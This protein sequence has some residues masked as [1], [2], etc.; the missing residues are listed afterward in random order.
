[1]FK[2]Y[3]IKDVDFFMN[4]IGD[5][6]FVVDAKGI[7][8]K[9][10]QSAGEMLGYDKKQEIENRD[11]IELLNAIDDKGNVINKHNAALFKSIREGKK[12]NNAIRQLGKR[13]GSRIW[14]SITTTPI[15]ARGKVSG[16]IIVIRDI[17][18]ERQQEEYR[19]DFAHIASHNLRT[20]LGN[21][22]W[23]NEYI[24]SE[25][26]GK[27]NKVQKEYIGETYQTLKSMNTMVNDLLSVSRLPDKKVKPKLEKMAI[28]KALDSIIKDYTAY[29]KAQNIKVIIKKDTKQN[30]YINADPKYLGIILQNLVENAIRYAFPKTDVIIKISKDKTYMTFSCTNQG[31]GIPEDIHKFIFAK[32]FRAQNAM[33][34]Q[35]NGTGLGLYITQEM[36]RLNKGKIW[37]DSIPDK[38][39]TFYVKFKNF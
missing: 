4:S 18:E 15:K 25:K 24:L 22:L 10:N 20:P 16:A 39:T 30:H 13:D 36:V 9:S 23:S 5:G 28:E 35:G 2:P 38:E 1:M 29:A 34:K 3:P 32:F 6:I 17:T 14:A 37:F 8:K 31:I 27:L 11:A 7:V 19:T 12:V 21:L 33:K 26:A